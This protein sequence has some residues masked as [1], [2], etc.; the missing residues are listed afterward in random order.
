MNKLF[1][2]LDKPVTK[3]W[4]FYLWLLSLVAAI[5]TVDVGGVAGL[6]DYLIYAAF[7]T[8]LFMYIPAKIRKS[9]RGRKSSSDD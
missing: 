6:I 8:V 7:Q 1:S 9:L 5:R 4:I 2:V 3:D